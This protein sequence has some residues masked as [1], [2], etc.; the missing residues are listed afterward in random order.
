MSANPDYRDL[1]KIFLEEKVEYLIVGAHAVIF[2]AEPRYTKDIDIWVRPSDDN[3]SRVWRVLKKFG[4]PMEGLTVKDFTNQ[5]LVYQIG[6]EPNRI[7]IMMGIKGVEF[8]IA[9][10]NKVESSY[11]GIPIYIL[12]RNELINA[13]KAGS[14]PQDLL[15]LEKL[16]PLKGKIQ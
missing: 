3:A 11:D 5:E 4:A 7:D 16:I 12:G 13:K 8:D 14:R 10:K 2:Y 15:D 1:F 6:V 9:W